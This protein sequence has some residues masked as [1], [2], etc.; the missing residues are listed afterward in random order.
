MTTKR[1]NEI[2]E[3]LLQYI[4]DQNGGDNNVVDEILE[5]LGISREELEDMYNEE[6]ELGADEGVF[7]DE[8]W[9]DE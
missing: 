1:R 2:I 6:D 4:D 9:A 8:E 3:S 7:D 5:S